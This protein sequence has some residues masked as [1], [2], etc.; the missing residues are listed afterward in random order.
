MLEFDSGIR[1]QAIATGI[2]TPLHAPNLLRVLL[3]DCSK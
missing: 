2:T 3:E 1:Y